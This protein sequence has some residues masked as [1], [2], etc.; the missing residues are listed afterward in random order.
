MVAWIILSLLGG[1]A[2]VAYRLSRCPVLRV[3]ALGMGSWAT[4]CR[5]RK[6]AEDHPVFR[7][8]DPYP[9][10]EPETVRAARRVA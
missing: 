2:F 10:F 1:A 5:E 8:H 4:R 7:P 3:L 6:E 9:P